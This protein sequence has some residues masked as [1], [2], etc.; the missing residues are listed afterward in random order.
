MTTLMCLYPLSLRSRSL[1]LRVLLI[2]HILVETFLFLKYLQNLFTS[3]LFDEVKE[4]TTFL[5]LN[6]HL[7][8]VE[9]ELFTDVINQR[10]VTKRMKK[11]NILLI[12]ERGVGKP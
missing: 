12:N 5:F 7:K 6:G 9:I 1:L 4:L 11:K 10:N 8:N 3:F 2:L